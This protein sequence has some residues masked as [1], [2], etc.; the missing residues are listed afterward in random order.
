MIPFGP[1]QPQTTLLKN[2]IIQIHIGD[3]LPSHVSNPGVEQKMVK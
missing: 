2:V 3:L 1:W